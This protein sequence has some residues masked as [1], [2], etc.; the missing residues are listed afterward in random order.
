[1]PVTE[2]TPWDPVVTDR[3]PTVE[4]SLAE[5]DARLGELAC[6][7]SGQGRVEVNWLVP[8]RKFSVGP[9]TPFGTGRQRVNCTAPRNDGRYL[10][11]SHQWIVQN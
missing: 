8:D 2:I 7:V 10:W 3:Q 5:T 1:L 11:F 4:I 6:Y 9:A